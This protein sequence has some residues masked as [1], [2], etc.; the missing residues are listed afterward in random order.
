MMTNC[1]KCGRLFARQNRPICEACYRKDEEMF[2]IV[3]SFIKENKTLDIDDIIDETGA[4]KKQILRWVREGRIDLVLPEGDGLTC[5][6]CGRPIKVGRVC[7]RCAAKLQNSLGG[8]QKPKTEGIKK[9][10]NVIKV[11]DRH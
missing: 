10:S 3:R 11:T 2:E 4:G 9:K 8:I 5:S 7:K 1:P 6:K